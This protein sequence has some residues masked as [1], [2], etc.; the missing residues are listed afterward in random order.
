MSFRRELNKRRQAA[1]AAR[2]T[3]QGVAGH[4]A[5]MEAIGRAAGW[6]SDEILGGELRVAHGLPKQAFV[7]GAGNI[8]E[9]Y[10]PSYL[11]DGTKGIAKERTDK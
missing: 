3:E 4:K 6:T 7:P 2:A 9:K 5:A 10:S 11:L 1:R 8:V